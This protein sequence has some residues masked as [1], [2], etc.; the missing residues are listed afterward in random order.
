MSEFNIDDL[1]EVI[2]SA[3]SSLVQMLALQLKKQIGISKASE[4]QLAA[5]VAENAGLKVAHPQPFGPEMMKALDAYEK[6]QDEVPETGMLDAYFI[7]RDSIRVQTPATDAYLA[8]VR[9]QGVEMY[10]MCIAHRVNYSEVDKSNEL[11]ALSFAEGLRNPAPELSPEEVVEFA[12]QLR[13]GAA[14]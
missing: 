7:L 5:V 12:A 6:H 2:A 9:A 14:L 3:D 10:A 8:E 4:Q 11:D 13:Q 1:D